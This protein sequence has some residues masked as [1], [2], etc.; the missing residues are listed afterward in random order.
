MAHAA[1]TDPVEFRRKLLAD[2]P[3]FKKVL[4]TAVGMAN[5]KSKSW[6]DEK[7]V[8]HAL[9]ACPIISL[10]NEQPLFDSEKF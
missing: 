7:G 6:Q 3:R 2:Q 4:D 10:S 1:T 8:K 5:W 9:G